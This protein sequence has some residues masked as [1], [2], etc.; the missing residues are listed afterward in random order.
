MCGWP[1]RCSAEAGVGAR[2]RTVLKRALKLA[3]PLLATSLAQAQ[4][5]RVEPTLSIGAG[6]T[7]LGH[8]S[9]S[10]SQLALQDHLLN[11]SW[12]RISITED[13]GS[14]LQA[15]IRL[16]S[17]V[18]TDTGSVGGNGSGGA[19][20]WNRLSWLGLRSAT[21]GQLTLGRQ[22]HAANDR[23]IRSFDAYN[24]AGSSLHVVP[25]SLFG[26]NRYAG[27]DARA[28]NSLKY[29]A[30]VPG[31]LE[32]GLSVGLGEGTGGDSRSVDLALVRKGYEVA[33]AYVS[34]DAPAVVAA[35]GALPRHRLLAVGGNATL[36]PVRA[37]LARGESSLDPTV[38]GR[39]TQKNTLTSVSLNWLVQPL[40]T[41]KAAWYGDQ[42]KQLN[43]VTGRDGTKRTWV[44]SAHHDLSRRT[45][46]S[47]VVFRNEFSGG[48][49]LEP[50]NLNA[51][52][53]SP[54]QS[55]VGGVSLGIRYAF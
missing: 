13:L 33:A 49:L 32:L 31:L 30:A 1:R 16:E 44:V 40:W 20:F 19:K 25:F 53:R 52:G 35:T 10:G 8:Q 38:A 54:T 21:L 41:L 2:V 42:A 27:N 14:G 51:L 4:E 36:G 28:D 48:Y 45:E 5:R 22:F 23:I 50:I 46:L 6:V 55:G 12:L 26:V 17:S 7:R 43:G 11:A 29:R 37:Y 24:A 18:G 3:L 9:G 15:L 47:A 39:Q 34:F